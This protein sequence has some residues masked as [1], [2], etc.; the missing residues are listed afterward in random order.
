MHK[1][2]LESQ[3]PIRKQ[4]CPTTQIYQVPYE[5]DDGKANQDQQK[6]ASAVQGNGN[7]R[8]LAS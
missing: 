7:M 6:P 5:C 8:M 3:V 2:F 4:L 1:R